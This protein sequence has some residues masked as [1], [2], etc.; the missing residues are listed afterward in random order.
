MIRFA[1]VVSGPLGTESRLYGPFD[2]AEEAIMWAREN[3]HS[4]CTAK[5]ATLREPRPK[6]NPDADVLTECQLHDIGETARHET[7]G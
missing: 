1:L 2:R 3:V 5:I 4:L 6:E 7:S